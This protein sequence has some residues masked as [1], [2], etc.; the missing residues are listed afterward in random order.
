MRAAI[1][2]L[3]VFAMLAGAAQGANV[4]RGRT[5]QFTAAPNLPA[6][7][8]GGCTDE[9]DAQQLTDGQWQQAAPTAQ[10]SVGWRN[11][12]ETAIIVDLQCVCQVTGVRV[13]AAG[14]GAGGVL[15][16]IVTVKTS[17]NGRQFG[18]A[19]TV[20][21]E[22]DLSGDSRAASWL[23][24]TIAPARLAQFVVLELAAESHARGGMFILVDEIEV[25][26]RKLGAGRRANLS[27]VVEAATPRLELRSEPEKGAVLPPPEEGAYRSED[28]QQARKQAELLTDESWPASWR[29]QEALRL[30]AQAGQGYLA[31]KDEGWRRQCREVFAAWSGLAFRRQ[32]VLEYLPGVIAAAEAVSEE[33]PAT[34]RRAAVEAV[35]GLCRVWESSV[36]PRDGLGQAM[37][38]GDWEPAQGAWGY[39]LA[40]RFLQ[41]HLAP[42]G[43]PAQRAEQWV[44]AA[45]ET[46]DKHLA[47]VRPATE[48]SRRWWQWGSVVCSYA[49]AAGRD[50]YFTSEPAARLAAAAAICVGPGGREARFGALA[51]AALSARSVLQRLA[52]GA[53][54]E[55]WS[56]FAEEAAARGG[57][58]PADPAAPGTDLRWS[59]LP[60]PR[61]LYDRRQSAW[62]SGGEEAS[63]RG[64]S[65]SGPLHK[66]TFDKIALRSGTGDEAQYLLLDG[67]SG[68]PDGHVDGNC[69][70]T[71]MDRGQTFLASP[72]RGWS[73]YQQNG[74]FVG[75][76]GQPAQEI[77]Y[78][79]RLEAAASLATF[80]YTHTMLERFNGVDW[81]RHLLWNQG[82]F[83]VVVDRLVGQQDGDYVLLCSWQSPLAGRLEGREWVAPAEGA[84]F[85]LVNVDGARLRVEGLEGEGLTALRQRRRG[86]LARNQVET[87]VNVV[88]VRGAGEKPLTVRRVSP[89]C[90]EVKQGRKPALVG[91]GRQILAAGNF[92][93]EVEAEAF[94][95]DAQRIAMVGGRSLNFAGFDVLKTQ[96]AVTLELDL[97]AGRGVIEV[98]RPTYIS[99]LPSLVEEFAID[100]A[101]VEWKLAR[102]LA[103]F[104]VLPGRHTLKTAQTSKLGLLFKFQW[105][106]LEDGDGGVQPPSVEEV[107]GLQA[108]ARWELGASVRDMAAGWG[109]G[110]DLVAGTS[111]RVYALALPDQQVW[112]AALE[113][114]LTALR[115][116]RGGEGPVVLGATQG[117]VL[118]AW[119]ATGVQQWERRLCPTGL[120]ATDP[121]ALAVL[122]DG[123]ISLRVLAG[124]AQGCCHLL[125]G[126]GS[127]LARSYIAPC[128]ITQAV[129]VHASQTARLAAGT[130][131]AGMGLL[132]LSG[133]LARAPDSHFAYGTDLALRAR[134]AEQGPRLL[135]GYEGG[136]IAFDGDGNELWNFAT[137][138]PVPAAIAVTPPDD[139]RIVAVCAAVDGLC[140]ALD[141]EGQIVWQVDL[142]DAATGMVAADLVGSGRRQ[143]VAIT[144]GRQV[145]VLD[146]QGQRIASLRVAAVPRRVAALQPK[147][148]R[149]RIAVGL[150]DGEVLVLEAAK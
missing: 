93:I 39:Y 70:L 27:E 73:L 84:E 52:A 111:D 130:G 149:G 63:Y 3:L 133:S 126:E 9:S 97:K 137:G 113:G 40:G 67:L 30:L 129:G 21:P 110:V 85:R 22:Q 91:V 2:R 45:S 44:Q 107:G 92:R 87:F 120:A 68:L 20:R 62:L 95:V 18:S 101:E 66:Y 116:A 77:P 17:V 31:T 19:A 99:V 64:V 11:L 14:G 38:Q 131:G 117:G 119:S 28:L 33:V 71:L 42:E 58:R 15:L 122:N 141:G 134:S 16:P 83:I 89:T 104:R 142:G 98:E 75:R 125:D 4:C 103:R 50:G 94:Y 12:P 5:V 146:L 82:R 145:Q 72:R 106:A 108:V 69:I 55:S 144:A 143:V 109:Q 132:E 6:V 121:G 54:A 138:C 24:A 88:Y 46:L 59:L 115:A 112:K 65:G 148:G 100:G 57:L 26:G 29:G 114:E 124:D 86:R 41:R 13:H 60:L 36:L 105:Q 123:S 37:A 49:Q 47:L 128:G 90:V 8:A 48:S 127:V 136:L 34:D 7:E 147:D 10:G 61:E 81:H 53:G 118:T 32:A 79:C 78:A 150:E 23:E 56:A 140:T 74:V 25:S 139:E 96:R 43:L 102:A 1:G 80:G 35:W 76:T 51:G 135:S